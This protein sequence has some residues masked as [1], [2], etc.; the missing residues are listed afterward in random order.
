MNWP[1]IAARLA[2]AVPRERL[3]P[4]VLRWAAASEPRESWAVALSGGA[5]SVALL[6][7]LWAHFPERRARL[8]ALHFDHRLR[9]RASAADARFCATLCRALGVTLVSG[10]WD[11]SP[12]VLPHPAEG[13]ATE[14]EARAARHAFFS[15][16]LRRRR[17]VTA[18]F[19][20]HHRDDVAETLLMRLARGSGA[21]GL[22]APR[23]VHPHAEFG[24]THL[25]PLLA[26]DKATLADALRAAGG[27]WREDASNTS[28]AHLRNRVRA[29]LLPAWRAAAAEPGRDPLAGLALTRDLLEE[30]DQALELWATRAT[31]LDA[32]G[33]LALAPLRELPRAVLR[34]VVRRWLASTPARTDL[35]R[36]GFE[37]LLDLV[38][39][40]R[41]SARHSLGAGHF[42]RLTRT[43]LRCEAAPRAAG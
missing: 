37:A 36:R 19:T 14:T 25:R 41:T 11:R 9:G 35:N 29:E 18:L 42:A 26:L 10:R 8:L 22:A 33:D 20:G 40:G 32:R 34:R 4:A 23:P 30:D 24:R 16:A 31:R 13:A 39:A 3:H 43:R 17:G 27:R 1:R 7:L 28:P 12:R 2:A 21:A 15:A 38:A 6:L 5:D